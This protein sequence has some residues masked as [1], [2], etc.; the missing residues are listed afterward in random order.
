MNVNG[1]ST[2]LGSSVPG[3]HPPSAPYPHLSSRHQSGMGYDYLWGGHPQYGQG[4]G[5]SPGHGMHQK[6]PASG[7]GQPQSQHHFQGH[8]QYQLNGDIESSPQPPVAGPTNIPLTGNQYWNRS[9][10]GS[11]QMS[12]NSHNMYGT[13]QSQAH[14]GITPSQH[15]QQQ[16]LQHP[17]HQ[18]S[19][20]HLHSQR[21]PHHHHQQH[22]QQQ[23]YGMMPNGIPYYQQQ[24][25]QSPPQQSQSQGQAQMMPQ[26]AQNFTPPRGS[27]QHHSLGRGSTGS[28]LPVGMSTPILSPTAM[29][30][31]GS[32][33]GHN[34]ER[35]PHT[36]SVGMSSPVQGSFLFILCYSFH[37]VS[38]PLF[39]SF[40]KESSLLDL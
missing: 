10:P 9:N 27:P 35:S 28:P 6:Q 31:S 1:V 15:H 33:K 32:P 5:T 11:Q 17:P 38:C 2:V 19:Q 13:Y 24:P 40:Q 18:S 8:G 3:S 12:Y 30:D 20:Q 23:H 16:S 25:Q 37:P 14:P 34:R 22:Q 26:A 4:M 7:M 21:Q 39:P 36:S 29:Q